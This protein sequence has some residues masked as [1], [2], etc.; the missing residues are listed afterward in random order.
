MAATCEVCG[1]GPGFGNNVS[2]S[3]R[4]TK[5]RWNPNIQS[6]RTK[7]GGSSKR[8]NVCTSCLKAGKVPTA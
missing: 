2:H 1:K 6:V 5:R 4:R 7:S 3:N 8:V